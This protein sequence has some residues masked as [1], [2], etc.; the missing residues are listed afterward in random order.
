MFLAIRS[1]AAGVVRTCGTAL[2]RDQLFTLRYWDHADDAGLICVS[3]YFGSIHYLLEY[4][5][6]PDDP[7]VSEARR[8]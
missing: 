3:T 8:Y 7:R 1:T 2:S 6:R 4:G 5:L